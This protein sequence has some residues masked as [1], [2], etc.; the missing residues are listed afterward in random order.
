[1]AAIDDDEFECDEVNA[2]RN[3]AIELPMKHLLKE[4]AMEHPK[5][6]PHEVKIGTKLYNTRRIELIVCKFLI[7][8]VL[9]PSII[10]DPK[11]NYKKVPGT[12]ADNN[13]KILASTIWWVV[14]ECFPC[15]KAGLALDLVRPFSPWLPF[16]PL[17]PPF[18]FFD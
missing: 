17:I 5:F 14:C 18:H 1:L 10:L 8:K 2:T 11:A 6:I 9:I 15:Y 12:L 3:M 16:F 7:C 13:L 4:M